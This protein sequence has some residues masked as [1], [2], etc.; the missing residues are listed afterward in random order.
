MQLTIERRDGGR[1]ILDGLG[2]AQGF[3]R[4]DQ[5]SI[6]ERSF[7]SLAG[8]GSPD[9][10]MA[11]DIE[12]INSTMR[13][14]S[15]HSAWEGFFGQELSWLATLSP[16]LD[17][18]AMDED[19]WHSAG[20]SDLVAAALVAAIGPWRGPSVATKV[21]HLKRPKLFPVLDENVVT[22]L[23]AKI[24][25]NAAYQRRAE[26]ALELALH[27]R[28]QGRQNLGILQEIQASL[29]GEG[30]KRSLVRI[31]DAVLWFAHPA[32]GVSGT[33]REISIAVQ[34]D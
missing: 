12:A 32:A 16:D 9:T 4:G 27:V 26:L 17:L 29:A 2:L 18:I 28:D 7:D 33:T 19:T 21:L 14:R 34:P 5:S 1:L 30:F 8:H 24:P 6:G 25:A 23:G 20:A 3:F 10:L 11:A 13:S 15:R 22:M 31:L